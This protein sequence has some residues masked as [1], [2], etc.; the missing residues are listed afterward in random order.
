MITVLV[1]S[2]IV[3]LSVVVGVAI[4]LVL[5]FVEQHNKILNTDN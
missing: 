3:P 1:A 5:H 4:G 2:L